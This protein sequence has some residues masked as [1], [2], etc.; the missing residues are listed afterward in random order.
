ML[1]DGQPSCAFVVFFNLI[2]SLI[3]SQ[4]GIGVWSESGKSMTSKTSLNLESDGVI[5][6]FCNNN[7]ISYLKDDNQSVCGCQKRQL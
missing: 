5:P 1:P 4:N 2:G 3:L 6:F 7:C